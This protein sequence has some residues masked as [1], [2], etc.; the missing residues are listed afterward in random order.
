M[1][2]VSSHHPSWVFAVPL[3]GLHSTSLAWVMGGLPIWE[4]G[5]RSRCWEA[6]PQQVRP[7]GDPAPLSCWGWGDEEGVSQSAQPPLPL[8]PLLP[9]LFV[10]TTRFLFRQEMGLFLA[11]WGKKK[12]ASLLF[13]N[14]VCVLGRRRAWWSSKPLLVGRGPAGPRGPASLH[15]SLP[16]QPRWAAIVSL[17]GLSGMGS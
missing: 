6:G 7:S 9:L 13:K 2:G 16:T 11:L 8:R 17:L 1:R 12:N 5:L 15:G 14:M 10:G 4:V 3:P